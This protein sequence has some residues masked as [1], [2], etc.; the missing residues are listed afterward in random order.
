[1]NIRIL[2]PLVVGVGVS[3]VSGWRR[4]WCRR[5]RGAK[6]PGSSTFESTRRRPG[7]VG[8][9]RRFLA[10]GLCLLS[11]AGEDLHAEVDWRLSIKVVAD[12]AGNIP[13]STLPRLNA[14]VARANRLLATYRR[15]FGFDLIEI[16]TIGGV[17]QWYDA[18]PRSVATRDAIQSAA[19]RDPALYLYRTD[20]IN[21]YVVGDFSGTCS[22]PNTGNDVITIGRI[23]YDTLLLHEC[24]H[25]FNL[26]HTHEGQVSRHSDNSPCDGCTC[27][28]RVPGE[29]DHTDETAPDHN[30]FGSLDA[31]ARGA[32]SLPFAELEGSRQRQ[33]RNTFQNIMSYHGGDTTL[34][35]LTADQMDRMTDAVNGSR[36]AV[37]T[38]RVWYVAADGSDA[39]PGLAS[40]RRLRTLDRGLGLAAARDV[41]LL[42][43]GVYSGP[44]TINQPVTLCATRG[45]VDLVAP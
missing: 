40:N 35:I 5:D 33:V 14:E 26:L 27:A 21:V 34:S 31:I 4:P 37:A 19:R 45:D 2:F 3:V 9:V 43:A 11:L 24:G 29:Q 16:A 41:V 20:A 32:F 13:A 42:K 44:V 28:V 25:Y 15:G 17:S 10:F 8:C 18:D 39:N 30:C 36:R 1:M 22:F 23:P 7:A 38:G 12:A 6:P